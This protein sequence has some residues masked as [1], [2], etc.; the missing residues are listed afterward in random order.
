MFVLGSR[1][2]VNRESEVLERFFK[3]LKDYLRVHQESDL[4][5]SF[6]VV[7]ESGIGKS[8]SI[9]NGLEESGK[10]SERDYVVKNTYCTPL[11]FYEL[12]YRNRNKTIVCDDISSIFRNETSKKILL[13]SLWSPTGKRIVQYDS[14]S[15]KLTVPNRFEFTGKIIA[16][17]NSLPDELEAIK[18]RGLFYKMSFT[19]DQKIEIL[20]E[21]C[22]VNDIPMEIAEFI[23]SHTEDHRQ[24][25]FRLPLIINEIYKTHREGDWERLSRN[26]LRQNKIEPYYHG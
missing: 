26:Q 21:I 3:P 19:A 24:I 5:H 20:Y 17:A 16:I 9:I 6:I 14:K 12:L 4:I 7:G 8:H 15:D 25:N 23:V 10:R 11:A 13:S 1:I 18:S 22:R 2:H